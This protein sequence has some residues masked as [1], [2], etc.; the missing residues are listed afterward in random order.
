MEPV[1]HV[2][3]LSIFLESQLSF[4][5]SGKVIANGHVIL[6]F[7]VLFLLYECDFVWPSVLHLFILRWKNRAL[8]FTTDR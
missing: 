5:M 6:F 2:S 7:Y 3:M 1:T 4:G 8:I